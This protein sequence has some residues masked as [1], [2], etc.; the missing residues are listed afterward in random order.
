VAAPFGDAVTPAPEEI[1]Y[2]V[3]LNDLPAPKL[4]VYPRYTV[5]AEKF[6][7]ITSLGI[8]NSRMKDF[9]DLWVLT[10]HSDLDVTIQGQ[11]I[12]GPDGRL[13]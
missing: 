4:R 8:A 1:E 6:A 13:Q 3:L 10:R 11:A 2:P 7:A 12:N 9:F 5:I